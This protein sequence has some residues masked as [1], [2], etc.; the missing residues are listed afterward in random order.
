VRRIIAQ[1]IEE[2]R[3]LVALIDTSIRLRL[4]LA[5][6]F[7]CPFAGRMSEEQVLRTLE[8]EAAVREYVKLKLRETTGRANPAHVQRLFATSQKRFPEIPV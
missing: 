1:S 2:N 7:D 6:S 3:D 5:T 4:D 8:A